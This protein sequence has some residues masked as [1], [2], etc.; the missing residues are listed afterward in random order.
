[1]HSPVNWAMLGLIIERPSYVYALASRFER[2]YGHALQLSSTSHAYTA[3]AALHERGLVEEVPGT[4]GGSQPKPT[5]RATAKGL[6]DYHEWLIGQVAEE[7]RRQ[8]V[9]LLQLTAL[10][11]DPAKAFAVLDT[12]EQA[13]LADT[14]TRPLAPGDDRAPED[15]QQLQARLLDEE[16]RL[17][18]GAQLEWTRY[19]RHELK[20]L[21]SARA[22]RASS[23]PAPD[24][25]PSAS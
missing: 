7:R 12:Y 21:A 11:R 18:V 24:V 10:A 16:R 17:A 14:C 6:A 3:I 4:R 22:S 25:P 13:C 20:A 23:V 5:F 1:M 8:K 15:A 19:A 2:T 9:F